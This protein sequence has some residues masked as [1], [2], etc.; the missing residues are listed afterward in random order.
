MPQY[1]PV[2][3]TK[4]GRARAPLHLFGPHRNRRRIAFGPGLFAATIIY[5]FGKKKYDEYYTI[6]PQQRFLQ[7]V[8]IVPY[9]VLG[10]QLSMQG[11]LV[12]VASPPDQ[13]TVIT[14]PAGLPYVRGVTKGAGG[15]A[16]A[17]YN[18]LG[19]NGGPLPDDVKARIH[20]IGDACYHDYNGKKV[21]HVVGP[22][23][24]QGKWSEREAA[25]ELARAYRNVL[26]E[27]VISEA[28][29]LRLLPVSAG[30][31]SGP[32]Y[33]QMPALT[34]QAL[35]SGFEQLHPF[36]KEQATREGKRIELCVFMNREWD[37]YTTAFKELTPSAKL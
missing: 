14:D 15:A 30:V 3:F 26:H 2:K 10:T 23:F 27:F 24:R 37:M 31:F 29:T 7:G 18:F 12:E 36:D 25:I 33:N 4:D 8:R 1:A 20:S 21:I 13:A 35:S 11:S 22:D 6:T 17:I 16:G 5:Y 19:L 28:D 32:L 34:Q 9:G